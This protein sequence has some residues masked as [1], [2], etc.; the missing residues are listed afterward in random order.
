[1]SDS[2]FHPPTP[3]PDLDPG[4]HDT[5]ER[6]RQ[7]LSDH[8]ATVE[9]SPDA[10]ARLAQRVATTDRSD[11]RMTSWMTTP[12]LALTA[13]AG[14]VLL[15]GGALAVSTM[16]GSE[17]LDTAGPAITSGP[18]DPVGGQ[19]E[20]QAALADPTDDAA[21]P[22]DT[23]DDPGDS[24]TPDEDPGTLGTA[25][26][27]VGPVRADRKAAG[28]AFLDLIGVRFTSLEVIGD[29]IAVST[30]REG[31]NEIFREVA[32]LDLVEVNGDGGQEWAVDR[33]T[34]DDVVIDSPLPGFD[35]SGLA[36]L[37]VSGEG[38]GFEA[39]LDVEVRSATDGSLLHRTGTRGGNF[40]VLAPYA[41]D[42]P[43]VGTDEG[44]L[45][46]RSSG[47]ADDV[48]FPFAAVPFTFDGPPDSTEYVVT[49]IAANDPD[50]GLNVRS[51]PGLSSNKIGVLESGTSV[52][53]EPGVFPVRVNQTVWWKVEGGGT[54]G[55]VGTGFL[56]RA[57]EVP[58]QEL[59]GEAESFMFL[60]ANPE[61]AAPWFNVSRIGFTIYVE[62]T[63]VDLPAR[64][65]QD[66]AG[67]SDP[68]VGPDGELPS[69]ADLFSAPPGN[70]AAAITTD[71]P[72]TGFFDPDMR[73]VA[74][75][76]FRGLSSVTASYV[77]ADGAEHLTHLFYE[78]GPLGAEL[79]GAIVEQ[80]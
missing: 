54:D 44:W 49:T 62:G 61:I 15:I 2:G 50:G 7:T 43:L 33:V 6:L 70:N 9:P 16:S 26:D 20:D 14:A 77:G 53:R 28:Q 42:V 39:T 41:L 74:G 60:A 3:D 45:I 64:R 76:Y 27:V 23:A 46:V 31:T 8:G 21:D 72:A 75:F 47:G 10:Y 35:A 52:T 48:A 18:G 29:S 59:R 5:A 4:L 65:L 22:A 80:R 40:G 66:S 12:R 58:E 79:V 34:S 67:W 57:D 55:W 51:A 30:F 73:G 13:T 71:V 78:S 56:A 69:L 17:S 1:M 24:D 68:L 37:A 32:R 38:E 63:R 36:Q 11:R 19:A 25:T